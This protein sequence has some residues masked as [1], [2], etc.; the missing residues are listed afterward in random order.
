MQGD[1]FHG[2][3]KGL[4]LRRK[5]FVRGSQTTAQNIERLS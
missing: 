4:Q 1:I 3:T 5:I 2:Y